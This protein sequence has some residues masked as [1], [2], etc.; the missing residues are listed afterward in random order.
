LRSFAE[1]K[2]MREG[3]REEWMAARKR[4]LA[5]E[6]E[7]TRLRDRS[8]AERRALPWVRVDKEYTFETPAGK[9]SLSDLFEGRRQLL[10]YH[11]MFAPDWDVGCKSC[12]FWADGF[13]R[14]GVHLAARDVTLTAISRAPLAKLQ[15]FARRLGWTFA[16]AS[17]L[18]SDFNFDYGVSFSPEAIASGEVDYNF[19][20]HRAFGS[21]MPGISVFAKDDAGAVFHTYSCYA[22][23]IDAVNPTYQL[24]DLVPKGRDEEGL[25]GTMSWLRLRD[26]YGG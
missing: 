17:S 11:F 25:P 15:A 22:R 12:S 18:G 10:V 6:K 20:P 16:W 4:L 23:G 5:S 19:G 13:E 26:D 21:E 9:R 14:S 1:E 2:I 7:L 24:L 3:T 8:S